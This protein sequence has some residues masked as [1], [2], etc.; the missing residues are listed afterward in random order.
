MGVTANDGKWHHI[1]A[2]W[3][4]SDGQWKSYKDGAMVK[5]GTGLKKGYT[6]HGGGSLVLGQEQ[7]S[8]GG[9]FDASQSFQGMLT[10][11]NVWSFALPEPAIMDMSKCCRAGEGS[12]YMW[13]DFIYGMIGKPRLVVPSQCP[14]VINM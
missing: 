2:T 3:R 10:N 7:D 4:N 9:G 5:T 8:V 14:C 13:S 12:V 1:C 11:V 6:I